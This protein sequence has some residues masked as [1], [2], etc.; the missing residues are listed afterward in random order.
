M[1]DVY[2][3]INQTNLTLYERQTPLNPDLQTY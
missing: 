1:K 3:K 2:A